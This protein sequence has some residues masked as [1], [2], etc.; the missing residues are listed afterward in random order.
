MIRWSPTKISGG[1]CLRCREWPE[2][3]LKTSCEMLNGEGV[4]SACGCRRWT[5]TIRNHGRRRPHAAGKKPRLLE[6]FL[7]PWS[8]SS[9]TR[10]TLRRTVCHRDCGTGCCAWQPFRI[11]S[12][13]KRRPCACQ[14]TTSR[15]SSP[16]LK[17]IRNT[18]GCRA[19]ASRMRSNFCRI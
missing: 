11:P 2:L 14:H 5:K 7:K 4:S 19:A 1:F 13:T 16:A 10:S 18:S 8:S 9:G 6:T 12:S 3:Q 17:T 15:A